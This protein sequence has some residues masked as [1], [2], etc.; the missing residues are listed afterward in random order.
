ML[1]IASW[2]IN[3]VVPDY[4]NMKINEFKKRLPDIYKHVELYKKNKLNC[5]VITNNLKERLLN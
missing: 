3:K 4:N 5:A 1:N 2:I